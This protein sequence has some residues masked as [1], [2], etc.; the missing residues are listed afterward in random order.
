M[1]TTTTFTNPTY[2][3]EA[4]ARFITAAL[5]S[6]DTI[7]N[8]GV[9]EIPN[10]AFKHV[11]QRA[12]T[13]D[14]FI[15]AGSCDFTDSGTLTIDEK[16]LTPIESQINAEFC[17][18]TWVQSWEAASMGYSVLGRNL[19]PTFEEFIIGHFVAKTAAATETRIWQGT[20]ATAGSFDGY[21][22]ICAANPT[23][24]AGGAVVTGTTITSANVIEEIKKVVDVIPIQL[25]NAPD[26]RIYVSNHIFQSY[27]HALGGF[28]AGFGGYEN[29]GHNQSLGQSL[30][31]D[32]IQIFRAPGMPTNDMLATFTNYSPWAGIPLRL[33]CNPH[34]YVP[35]GRRIGGG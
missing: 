14:N 8:G 31:Y 19:P 11:I 35:P 7:A 5:L 9:T 29:K 4:S 34:P 6:G 33:R 22:T 16:I 15:A 25:L 18:K 3:G 23:D 32:G 1:A 26:L 24:L 12:A 27:T 30:L 17:S 21:T 28:A 20:V 10:I 13:D 2:S